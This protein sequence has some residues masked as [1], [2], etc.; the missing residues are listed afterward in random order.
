MARFRSPDLSMPTTRMLLTRNRSGAIR[1]VIA[2]AVASVVCTSLAGTGSATAQSAGPAIPKTT[3]APV[4]AATVAPKRAAP[5]PVVRKA[6][7]KRKV[8]KPKTSTKSSSSS[9]SSGKTVAGSGGPAATGKNSGGYGQG[10]KGDKVLALQNRLKEL[11]FDIAEP[12]GK[13]G[14][15]T[16]H[17]VMAF[18]KVNR[19]ART[20]RA[21]VATL[22]ALETAVEPAP[23]QPAGGAERVEIDLIN[24]YLGIYQNNVLVRLLSISSGSGKDFCVLD[25]DTQ[26]T[27]CDKAITPGGSFRVARRVIGWRESKLGLLYNPLYFNGGIAIHGAA[28]VPGYPASHGCVRIP[29]TSSQ[30]FPDE[31]ADGTPVYV[32]GGEKAPVPLNA[33]A[34]ADARTATTIAGSATSTTSNATN[35]TNATTTSTTPNIVRTSL[36]GATTTPAATSVTTVV[37]QT[38]L[39]GT[40]TTATTATTASTTPT[41]TTTPTGTATTGTVATTTASSSTTSTSSTTTGLVRILPPAS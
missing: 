33:K 32:F 13:F 35:V 23:L 21:N 37:T 6:A 18:Q 9:G 25:P 24:Q 8:T 7:G 36:P 5:K 30:W 10:T 15:E 2:I 12:D 41:A 17:A 27:E 19:L 16:Y 14:D 11:K 28:S 1:S 29:M 39:A 22:T 38:T 34:P 26:K 4:T 31:V 40:A 3:S 20:G